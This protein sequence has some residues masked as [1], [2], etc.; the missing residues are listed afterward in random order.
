MAADGDRGAEAKA[1]RDGRKAVAAAR[2]GGR[3]GWP[4]IGA[5]VVLVAALIGVLMMSVVGSPDQRSTPDRSASLDGPPATTMVGVDT[6]PPWPA[7]ADASAAVAAAGLP[8][9]GA[10]GNVEHLH[11]HL[12]VLVD[13]RPV[14]VPAGIGIDRDNGGISPLHTHGDDG[15]IHVESPVRRRFT[16]GELFAEW[17]VGLSAD[18]V[19]GLRAGGGKTVRVFVNGEPQPGD[20]A[21]VVL[22]GRDQIAVVYG[23]PVSG[24]SIPGTYEF[25]DGQ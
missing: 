11:A 3:P 20:P 13:G 4:W 14:P 1:R 2:S 17:R 22:G 25:A 12:D 5:G 8:M 15:V 18:H 24:E 6:L 10:E 7:P 21:T 9:L 16:L 23:A 19:G